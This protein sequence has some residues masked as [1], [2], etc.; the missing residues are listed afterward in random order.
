MDFER[1]IFQFIYSVSGAHW[2]LDWIVIFFAQYFP[3]LLAAVFIFL[4]FW[5]HR[6]WRQRFYFIFLSAFSLLVARGL[7]VEIIR[8]FYARPRPFQILGIETLIAPPSSGS[9]PSGHA[10]AFFALAALVFFLDKKYFWYFLSGAFLISLA[11]IAAGV[12]WPLDIIAGAVIGVASVAVAK[13]FL[14]SPQNKK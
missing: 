8:F 2:L 7:L 12:H 5:N 6:K 13:A 3:Y 11:R 14:D 1:Q 10:T 9:M 4:I